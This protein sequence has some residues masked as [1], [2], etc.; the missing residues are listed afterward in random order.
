MG[1]AQK[2]GGAK[3]ETFDMMVSTSSERLIRFYILLPNKGQLLSE[4]NKILY[5]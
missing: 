3:P 2:E 1:N 5:I 4:Y